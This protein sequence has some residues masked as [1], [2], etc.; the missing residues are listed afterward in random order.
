MLVKIEACTASTMNYQ[1]NFL[2]NTE[3]IVDIWFQERY[4]IDV[5]GDSGLS[6]TF[7]TNRENYLKIVAAMGGIY[8]NEDL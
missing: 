1:R 4:Y 7:I 8:R 2:I 5:N 6:N 3:N